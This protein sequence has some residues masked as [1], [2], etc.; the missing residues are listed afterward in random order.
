MHKVHYIS[1]S[2][3]PALNRAPGPETERQSNPLLECQNSLLRDFIR[4]PLGNPLKGSAPLHQNPSWGPIFLRF[5]RHRARLGPPREK[6][7]PPPRPQTLITL[8]SR[9]WLAV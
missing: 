1:E 5:G 6:A 7:L 2:G 9:E 4:L 8:Q 3:S